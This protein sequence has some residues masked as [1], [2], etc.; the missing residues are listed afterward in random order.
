[1]K[2]LKSVIIYTALSIC[3]LTLFIVYENKKRQH[4]KIEKKR[5]IPQ[6]TDMYVENTKIL[7]ATRIHKGQSDHIRPIEDIINF[8]NKAESYATRIIVLVG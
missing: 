5:M 8:I 3:V 2:S 4:K 1:M 7:V 6:Q